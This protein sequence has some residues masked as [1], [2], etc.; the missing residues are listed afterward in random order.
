MLF[1]CFASYCLQLLCCCLQLLCCI[2][3]CVRV[4]ASVRILPALAVMHEAVNSVAGQRRQRARR[5]EVTFV[6]LAG[7]TV[8]ALWFDGN[9][10][11]VR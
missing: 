2:A 11:L 5:L 6:A 4:L 7:A 3:R 1:G 10:A 8:T 9:F